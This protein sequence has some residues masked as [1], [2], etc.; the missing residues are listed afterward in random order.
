MT[1]ETALRYNLTGASGNTPSRKR[2]SPVVTT[3]TLTA[4]RRSHAA[5][6]GK[7]STPTPVAPPESDEA[8]HARFEA[9]ALPYLDQLYGAALRMTRN[10]SDAE[11][12]VQDTFA[13]AY[14]RFDQFEPGTNLKAWL[15]R[16][17]Q[18]TFITQYRRQ[19]R[20]PQEAYSAGA[21][22]WE[23][24]RA[25]SHS[26]KGLPSAEAEALDRLPN[27]TIQ[28]AFDSL[29]E[30]FRMVVYLADVEGFSYKEIAQ[31]M[32]TPV[33]TVMSRLYRGRK[34]LRRQL[35]DYAA[36]MGIGVTNNDQHK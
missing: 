28:R 34:A 1:H 17:L 5:R 33:G 11:D 8:R 32:D 21:E 6:L 13:K 19:Q 22:E 31:I 18:N 15:Y 10:P 20:R 24:A 9:D 29:D 27:A 12:L 25:A 35:A 30:D 7:V 4:P 14:Q 36:E 3:S 2:V 23:E 26:A 16:I